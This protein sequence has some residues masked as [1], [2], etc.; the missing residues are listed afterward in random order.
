MFWIE[1]LTLSVVEVDLTASCFKP[2]KPN[3]D[4]VKWSLS[5]QLNLEVDFILS[6]SSKGTCS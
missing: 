4:R 6:W 5:E 3:Y 1:S 2:G